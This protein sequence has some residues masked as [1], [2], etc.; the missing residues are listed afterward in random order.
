MEKV[1]PNVAIYSRLGLRNKTFILPVGILG[2]KIWPR[3]RRY[4]RVAKEGMV[5]YG[6]PFSVETLIIA[7]NR[8]GQLDDQKVM[9]FIMFKVAELLPEEYRGCY[10]TSSLNS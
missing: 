7:L 1:K 2:N 6:Q 3:N 4:P 10:A 9:D 5:N 8:S